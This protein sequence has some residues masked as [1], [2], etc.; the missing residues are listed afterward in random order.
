VAS[1]G[2]GLVRLEQRRQR[3]EDLFR[4]EAPEE[5]PAHV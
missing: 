5:D 3:L 1:L 4:D 2:L